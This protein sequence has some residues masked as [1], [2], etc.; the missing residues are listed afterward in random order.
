MAVAVTATGLAGCVDDS[1]GRWVGP[2]EFSSVV[3]Q[4]VVKSRA[5]AKPPPEWDA[6][7]ATGFALQWTSAPPAPDGLPAGGPASIA[8]ALR[9]AGAAY[10]VVQ[11]S[12]PDGGWLAPLIR[13]PGAY[14]VRRRGDPANCDARLDQVIRD[15]SRQGKAWT[16]AAGQCLTAERVGS[17]TAPYVLRPVGEERMLGDDFKLTLRGEALVEQATGREVVRRMNL[18]QLAWRVPDHDHIYWGE[19]R[20]CGPESKTGP[21]IG[22]MGQRLF[23]PT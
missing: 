23:A 15:W 21:A 7:C 6:I 18:A 5:A 4:G 1:T 19:N 10:A 13:E 17:P 8:L 11:A 20:Y 16:A 2:A 12:D 22:L 3:G 9:R 14:V